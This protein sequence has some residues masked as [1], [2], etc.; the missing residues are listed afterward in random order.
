MT[1]AG[2]NFEIFHCPGHS[3]GSVVFFNRAQRFALVGDV[4]FRGS[5]GRTDFPY[6]DHDGVDLVDQVE[7][8]AARRRHRL[9]LRSWRAGAIRP[10]A[11]DQSVSCLNSDRLRTSIPS[12]GSRRRRI[13]ATACRSRFNTSVPSS[14][15]RSTVSTRNVS[16]QLRRQSVQAPPGNWTC[17]P[18]LAGPD[19]ARDDAVAVVAAGGND[20][21]RA[22][23]TSEAGGSPHRRQKSSLRPAARRRLKSWRIVLRAS[24]S[25]SVSSLVSPLCLP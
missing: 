23:R 11:P 4:L 16:S 21:A 17:Q 6:G 19:D 13:R 14:A 18:Y 1:V 22:H 5:I 20:F 7:A 12:G 8:A 25:P 24:K 15:V 3:P 10:G 9:H 2:H